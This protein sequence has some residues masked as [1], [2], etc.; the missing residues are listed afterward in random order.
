[1]FLGL[2]HLNNNTEGGFQVTQ[3]LRQ[4]LKRHQRHIK[5]RHEAAEGGQEPRPLGGPEFRR[6]RVRYEMADR[7]RATP[8]G[9]VSV[10]HQLAREVGLVARL[11]ELGILKRH[12]PYTDSDHVLN[13]AFNALCGGRV[14]DDIEHRRWDA[15]FLD[16]LG[17]R[18]IP[19]PTTAG[20]FCRRFDTS[21]IMAM[22]SAINE[23]RIGV[24]QKQ[25]P[26]FFAET[27]RI[28][29]DG[30]HVT[31]LGECKQGMDL[32]YKGTWGYHPLLVTLANTG[33][34]LWLFNRSGNRPSSEGAHILFDE[35]IKLCRRAG[36][37][38]I[39]LRG[40]TDFSLTAHIDGWDAQGVRFIF[41]YDANPTFV[42]RAQCLPD[43]DYV[44]LVRKADQL[45]TGKPRSK[46]PR[47]KEHL[48][49]ERGYRNMTLWREDLAEF[50]HKPAR[51]KATY[52]IVVLRKE[53]LEH[54][55][56]HFLGTRDRYFFYITNDRHLT[57]EQV[58][59]EANDRC[60]QERIIEQLKGGVRALHAPLNTLH[61]NWA[62][63]VMMALAWSLKAWFA[64][65]LPVAPRWRDRHLFDKQR[66]LGMEF[67]TFVQ[68]FM[69]IPAQVVSS[70]RQFVLRF[71]TWRPELPVL[72]RFVGLIDTR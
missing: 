55:G 47:V 12:R 1:M 28:D 16:A 46:P 48:V 50:E 51:A 36:F 57:P 38:D 60:N 7:I 49:R 14:L 39:L 6:G 13:V 64:M 34:P 10:M 27:A 42:E 52:R 43:D 53:I 58:V 35:A 72:L 11:D 25:G 32:N 26:E 62:Y 54:E 71:L 61:A 24:W 33:E 5:Q 9:G 69:L 15:A 19:D 70:A 21:S 45:F 4:R 31:T 66:V 63:M 3:T 67:R 29:A 44:E 37:A 68:A 8:Y 23:T 2:R 18:T 59:R 17:A 40:D 56:Q 30:S 20:D 65:L 22:M 41:G